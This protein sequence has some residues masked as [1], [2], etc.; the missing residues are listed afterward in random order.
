[1]KYFKIESGMSVIRTEYEE[2]IEILRKA[3]QDLGING[4]I[5]F[6]SRDVYYYAGT[7]LYAFLI[8]PMKRDPILLVQINLERVRRDSWIRDI[9]PSIGIKTVEQV[10]KEIGMNHRVIGVEKDVLPA[11]YFETLSKMMSTCRLVDISPLILKQRSIKTQREIE[12]IKKAANISGESLKSVIGFLKPSMTEL[13]LEVKFEAVKRKKGHEHLMVERT[14]PRRG[15]SANVVISG[16][17]LCQISG[18]WITMTGS[19]LSASIPYGPSKRKIR[20]GDLI[21]INHAVVYQGYHSDEARMFKMGKTEIKE[22]KLY[23]IVLKALKTSIRKI[24]PGVKVSEIFK[25]AKKV[26]DDSGYGKYF[27]GNNQ[28]GVEYVGHGVGLE[29]NEVPF[30]GPKNDE[31]LKPGMVFALEP[32]IIIPGVIGIEIED[33]IVVTEEGCEVLTSTPKDEI[34][35]C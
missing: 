31:L 28:Y 9:R 27:M 18:Y 8:I 12:L 11:N 13:E 7:G 14:W 32:K 20:K 15:S 3:M 10:M 23:D 16:S 5:L 21:D 1:M 4:A 25:V 35:E 26:M 22:V 24:K 17:N 30:I 33:T 29:I 6:Y 2:R 19:G 34:M